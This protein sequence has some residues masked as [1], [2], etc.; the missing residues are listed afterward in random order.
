MLSDG[1]DKRF[2]FCFFIRAAVD[3]AAGRLGGLSS[4]PGSSKSFHFSISS[5][6][7]VRPTQPAIQCI[8][9]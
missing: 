6:P 5:R 2:F 1:I 3:M 4:S 9:D 8:R 7:I